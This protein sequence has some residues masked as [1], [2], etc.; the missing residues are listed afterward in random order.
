VRKCGCSFRFETRRMVE[1]M[2]KEGKNG[3]SSQ[4]RR[5]DFDIRV[6]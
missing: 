1:R 5:V 4:E 3:M 2:R 6:S